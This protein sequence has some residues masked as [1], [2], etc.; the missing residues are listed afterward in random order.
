M[1]RTIDPVEESGSCPT[2]MALVAKPMD[3][4]L[5]SVRACKTGPGS[6]PEARAGD[7]SDMRKAHSSFKLREAACVDNSSE[8]RPMKVAINPVVSQF[9]PGLQ[10]T[11]ESAVV[12]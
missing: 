12:Q 11:L 8:L 6:A 1:G 9:H 4:L 2:W 10:Q 3:I 5:N 7:G